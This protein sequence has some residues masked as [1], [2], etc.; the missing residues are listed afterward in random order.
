[1]VTTLAVFHLK[2]GVGKTAAAV[3]LSYLAAQSGVQT[4]LCDLDPQGSATYYFRVKPKVKAAE[5]IFLK[6]GKHIVRN[7]KG[8]DY[9]HLDLLPADMSYRRLAV[10]LELAKQSKQRLHTILEPLHDA[11]PYIILDCPPNMTRI[12]ENVFI[13][14]DYLL[15]PV[16]PSTL[17]LRAY[18]QL[19]T[20]FDDKGYDKGKI[21]TFFSMV[22]KKKKMHREIMHEMAMQSP[23]LLCST[24]PYLADIEKMGVYREPVLAF[25]PH[26]L[27]SR[28]YRALWAEIQERVHAGN[29]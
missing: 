24:I 13:A 17:A 1:M 7:I 22:E 23:H 18:T 10:T 14:A 25:A 29:S 15:V 21:V 11:Y 19:L 3:N 4:L 8:T 27:A 16:V 2:G 6:G 5:K 20:F 9:E 12:A 28:A 26:A